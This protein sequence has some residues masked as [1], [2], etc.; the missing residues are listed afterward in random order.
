MTQNV[1]EVQSQLRIEF[2][3]IVILSILLTYMLSTRTVKAGETTIVA[4]SS[5]SVESKPTHPN[6]TLENQ[7]NRL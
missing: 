5:D 3:L 7:P 4:E 2:R 6:S 1:K